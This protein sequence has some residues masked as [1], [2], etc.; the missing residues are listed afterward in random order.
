MRG[1]QNTK[2]MKKLTILS[3]LVVSLYSCQREVPVSSLSFLDGTWVEMAGRPVERWT[4]H[5]GRL[6]GEGL[7]INEGDT[8][9]FERIRFNKLQSQLA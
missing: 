3:L 1:K 2:P 7:I 6:E 8:T 9:V 5:K 4:F